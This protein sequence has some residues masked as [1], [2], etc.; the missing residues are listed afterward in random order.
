MSAVPRT[1]PVQRLPAAYSLTPHLIYP[2]RLYLLH[3]IAS[4]LAL[5]AMVPAMWT[6]Q[7]SSGHWIST[8]LIGLGWPHLARWRY[9]RSRHPN[10]AEMQNVLVDGVL[11]GMALPLIAF[12][13]P[14]SAALLAVTCF[15]A[16]FGGGPRLLAGN[17]LAFALGVLAGIPIYGLHWSPGLDGLSFL[18]SLPLAL[19]APLALLHVGYDVTRGLHHRRN[20]L[21]LRGW[22]DGLSGLFNRS[23]WEDT[24]RAE[25]ARSRRT[26]QPATLVLAD[27]DHFKQINDLYGHAEGDSVIRRFADLLRTNLRDI[28][29]PGRYG[30]EEFGILLPLT[31]LPEAMEVVRRLHRR[32]HE[33]PLSRH[34]TITA[35][36]GVAELSADIDSPETWI[37]QA[38]LTLYRAKYDGRDR[39]AER[40]AA[41]AASSAIDGTPPRSPPRSPLRPALSPRDPAVLAQLL[42][43]IDIADT[44]VAMYNPDD[45]LV[46]ANDAYIRLHGIPPG[47]VRFADVIRH[48]HRLRQGVALDNDPD[49]WLADVQ[50]QRRRA[51]RRLFPVTTLDGVRFQGIEVCFNDGWILTTLV[52]AG[53]TGLASPA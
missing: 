45:Q 50:R 5:A 37:R 44:P 24:V 12:N 38:D 31:P 34:R 41:P 2:H 23:H 28:D 8:L 30:G 3:V 25:F 9:R 1:P 19:L 6:L 20:E 40:S 53:P 33:A 35:S 26:G 13:L 36:F 46:M 39:I 32:L 4:A 27:L 47:V 52:A 48:A 29:V 51:P 42:Q 10:R 18:A 15:A 11:A 16:M 43:G 21:E 49:T 22:H 7:V 14:I 17:L